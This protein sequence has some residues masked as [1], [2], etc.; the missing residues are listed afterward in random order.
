MKTKMLTLLM[1]TF[2][3]GTYASSETTTV[4]LSESASNSSI[5]KAIS[6][7]YQAM[8]SKTEEKKSLAIEKAKGHLESVEKNI[9][10][11]SALYMD[12]EKINLDHFH[13]ELVD[14]HICY[15]G[16]SNE[17]FKLVQ[18]LVKQGLFKNDEEWVQSVLL[19]GHKINLLIK[20]GPNDD[21]WTETIAE[22]N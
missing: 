5:K 7:L 8:Q 10:F 3:L 21:E 13:V 22:C 6:K 2:C 16:T 15:K 12:G 11:Q 19:S 9:V 17:A 1:I 20:D 14:L 18:L 4:K